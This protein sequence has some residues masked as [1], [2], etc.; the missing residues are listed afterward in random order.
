MVSIRVCA[1]L[2]LLFAATSCFVSYDPAPPAPNASGPAVLLITVDTLRADHLGAYG[3][4]LPASPQIDRLA[5][6]GV[7]FERA[8]AGS[9][10]TAPSHATILTSRFPREHSIGFRNGDTR[11]DGVPTIAAAFSNAGYATAAFVSNVVLRR[12]RGFETGFDAYDDAAAEQEVNRG[13]HERVAAQTTDAALAW[14]AN[15]G[16]RPFFLWVHYQDPHGPYSPPPDYRSRF[17]LAGRSWKGPLPVLADNTGIGGIPAYQVLGDLRHPSVYEDR[18]IDEIFYADAS[19]GRLIEAADRAAGARRAIVLLTADHGESFGEDDQY[20]VHRMTTPDI[21]H[22][23]MLLRA[24]GLAPRRCPDLV[25]HVD[26]LPTL[27]E[28]A[29]IPAPANVS[30]VALGPALRAAAPLPERFV[31]TDIGA[32]LSAYTQTGFLR[33]RGVE[34]AWQRRAD[35][36][37]AL[38]PTATRYAWDGSSAWSELGAQAV[39]PPQVDRYLRSAVP[40]Q[41]AADPSPT[42]IARLQALGYLEVTKP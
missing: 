4:G 35:A 38:A 3:L 31:F 29:G 20:F 7:L 39:L 9:S 37:A 26:V 18:Y 21:A 25:S 34:A 27:L 16:G 23:P 41:V 42:E 32:E 6:D 11:L 1:A 8:V 24:P 30:G 40:M 17:H 14:L 12:G 13:I 10:A 15:R 33:I 2:G 22:V 36:H 19:I 5:A 28:L